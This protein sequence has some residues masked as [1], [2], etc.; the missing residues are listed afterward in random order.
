MAKEIFKQNSNRAGYVDKFFATRRHPRLAWLHSIGK[1][2]LTAASS[3]LQQLYGAEDLL[4]PA[5]V[6]IYLFTRI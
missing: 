4:I 6:G 3:T 1:G 2:Q 5:K